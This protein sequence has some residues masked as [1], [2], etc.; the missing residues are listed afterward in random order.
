MEPE[1]FAACQELEAA[2]RQLRSVDPPA[3]VLQLG[4]T[5]VQLWP[6]PGEPAKK[7]SV[8]PLAS[9]GKLK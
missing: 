4:G 7:S 6:L 8:K 3:V 9:P 2:L 1:R 5:T